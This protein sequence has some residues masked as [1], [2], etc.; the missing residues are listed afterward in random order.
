MKKYK[1]TILAGSGSILNRKVYADTF[2]TN[3]NNSTTSGYYA[4]Y[5]NNEFV[6]SYP[7]E[8]TIIDSVINV[9]K[10]EV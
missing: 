3:T 6:A 5:L 4:F 9:E 2:Q 8:R 7:I 1:L 10:S